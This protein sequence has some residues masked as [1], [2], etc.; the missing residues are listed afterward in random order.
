MKLRSRAFSI[1]FVTPGY[2]LLAR[3][4]LMTRNLEIKITEAPGTV[5]VVNKQLHKRNRF[6]T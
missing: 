3:Q 2:S 5:L 1:V 4:S 6:A